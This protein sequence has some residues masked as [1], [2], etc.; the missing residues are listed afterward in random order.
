MSAPRS[1]AGR[2]YRLPTLSNRIAW[3]TV[4]AVPL[5]ALYL[6]W[7]Y[8][9]QELSNRFGVPFP[10]PFGT[11][12]LFGLALTALSF[13]SYVAKPTRAYGPISAV[14]AASLLAYLLWLAGRSTAGLSYQGATITVNF[15][16]LMLI[17]A[18]V[19]IL[20]LISALVT[21]L[22]DGLRPTERYPADFP[23]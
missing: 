17:A 16:E 11:V 5:A 21:T 8:V 18:V 2:T 3:G 9:A 7:P 14:S 15:S 6:G 19:P 12:L 10:F 22:E 1:A 23:A 4:R 20:L 13:L